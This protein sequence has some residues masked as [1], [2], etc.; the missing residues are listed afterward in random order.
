MGVNCK[1]KYLKWIK[2]HAYYYRRVPKDLLSLYGGRP[3]I[4]QS[5]DTSNLLQ[6][7]LRRDS[8]N[9]AIE[10]TWEKFRKT[11]CDPAARNRFEAAV[12]NARQYGFDY[13]TLPELDAA[14]V[15][16]L[17]ER[18]NVVDEIKSPAQKIEA[19]E[20]LLGTVEK[21][22]LPLS[23]A[24]EIYW[25]NTRDKIRGKNDSQTR[26]W[27]HAR[28]RCVRK[29]IKV[30]G[31][32]DIYQITRPDAIEYRNWWLD[33]VEADEV[34]ADTANKD[35]ELLSGIIQKVFD[36]QGINLKSP[37]SGGLR[38]QKG[39]SEERVSMTKKEIL[40]CLYNNN[41][42]AGLNEQARHIV[43]IC[44]ETGARPVE[45][46]TRAPNDIVLDADVP[47]FKIRENKF[48]MLKTKVS[49]RDIPLVGSALKAFQ[50]FPGGFPRYVERHV[51]CVNAIGKFFRE[52][53]ILVPGATLYSL[54]HGFQDRL[55]EVETPERMQV[56]LFGHALGRPKYGAGPALKVKQRWMQKL[57]LSQDLPGGD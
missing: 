49:R 19:A 56:E 18:L 24:L 20:A 52:N 16:E 31:D 34:K 54:R 4:Q 27:T 53:K 12:A 47:H 8:I 43:Y 44:A 38:L 45:V 33:L 35:M 3:F 40:H 37:F 15:S 9:E 6:A 1:D 23:E 41:P 25:E 42:L 28:K 13:K 48:G 50:K 55:N 26:I 30:I 14:P 11:G 32:K 21:P 22:E 29:F 10:E 17:V 39:Y 2:G 36:V 51:S 57:M 7:L 46:I 5:L